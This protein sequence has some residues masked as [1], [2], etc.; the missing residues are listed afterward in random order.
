MSNILDKKIP[1]MVEPFE[2]VEQEV[3]IYE[4]KINSDVKQMYVGYRISRN[5]EGT[6]VSGLMKTIGKEWYITNKQTVYQRSFEPETMFEPLP[7]PNYISP[8]ETPNETEFLEA[9]AFDYLLS[10]FK[11]RPDLFW[12]ILEGYILENWNSGWFDKYSV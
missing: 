8:E 4:L 12:V 3:N 1:N 9:P 10:T 7:N 11:S 6:D 2:T 5:I